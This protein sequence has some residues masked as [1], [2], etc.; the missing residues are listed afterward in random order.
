MQ[1]LAGQDHG[2]AGTGSLSWKLAA[3]GA[4]GRAMLQSL[5]GDG[6]VSLRAVSTPHLRRAVKGT[7]EL[8]SLVVP[9][10]ID[11]I[12]APFTLAG[13]HCRFTADMRS[14][15]LAGDGKGD[16]NLVGGRIDATASLRVHGQF[17]PLRIHGP[18]DD[19]SCAVDMELL[20]KHLGR[21]LLNTPKKATKGVEKLIPGKGGRLGKL[22]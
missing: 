15:G 19:V 16:V 10:R 12:D 3:A 2:V 9:E 21:D 22:F 4:G 6:K 11:S 20:M 14:Q 13:G 5:A 18:L 17:V 7:K 1:K 8:S